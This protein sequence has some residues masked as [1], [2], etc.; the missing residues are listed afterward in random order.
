ML[1][2]HFRDLIY[3]STESSNQILKPAWKFHNS[4]LQIFIENVANIMPIQK[5]E[6]VEEEIYQIEMKPLI[7]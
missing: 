6:E 7:Q 4:N 5:L 1:V 3:F 2:S